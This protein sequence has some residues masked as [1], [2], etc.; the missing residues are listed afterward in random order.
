MLLLL[1]SVST[2]T[3]KRPTC[4]SHHYTVYEMMPSH[5][6]TGP[7]SLACR[8]RCARQL[9]CG[10]THRKMSE[11]ALHHDT[12][13]FHGTIVGAHSCRIGRHDL[14][15]RGAVGIHPHRNHSPAKRRKGRCSRFDM[16]STDCGAR[17][18]NIHVGKP[19]NPVLM[20][21]NMT[22]PAP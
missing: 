20:S 3:G 12:Q 10:M 18:S 5:S 15:H 13:R 17:C 11:V 16:V 6:N 9:S 22:Q 21:W 7:H 14:A 1:T 4:R 2:L 8:A 19:H